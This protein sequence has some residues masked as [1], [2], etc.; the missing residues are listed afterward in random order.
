MSM[1]LTDILKDI[2]LE[3]A[4][5]AKGKKVPAKYLKGLKSKGEYGSKEAMKKEI[6]KF[7]GKK[8]YKKDW[9]ADFKD[10]KRIKTKKGAATKA[11]EKKFNEEVIDENVDKMIA[12][13]AKKS[14]IS[15]S[16][17][18]QV[19]NRGAQ[20]WNGGHRPGVTQQQWATARINSFITGVGGARKADKD[21]W[22]KAKKSKAK[23]K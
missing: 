6:D 16:I 1:N 7:A 20:A 14:G 22:A 9:K 5:T 11:F 2:L 23:K 3:A 8:E 19:Y 21:L 13:K 15:A 10:G 4:R 12:N 18:R 17:L